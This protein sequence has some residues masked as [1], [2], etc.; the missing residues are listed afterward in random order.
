MSIMTVLLL[1][2]IYLRCSADWAAGTIRHL[3]K[4]SDVKGMAAFQQA[5]AAFA[6]HER[7]ETDRTAHIMIEGTGHLVITI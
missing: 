3:K 5:E 1:L 4:A 2:D 6:T 7:I